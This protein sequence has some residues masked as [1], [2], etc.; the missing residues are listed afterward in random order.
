MEAAEDEV[1]LIDWV[2]ELYARGRVSTTPEYY[3]LAPTPRKVQTI[4]HDIM[5][6]IGRSDS[7]PQHLS[8]HHNLPTSRPTSQRIWEDI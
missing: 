3:S 7:H 4:H 8:S 6:G 1:V 2:R 5:V